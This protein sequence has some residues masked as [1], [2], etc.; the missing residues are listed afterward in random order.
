MSGGV[1]IV[2]GPS[3]LLWERS[4]RCFLCSLAKA[5]TAK[6]CR[7]YG[8]NN[9]PVFSHSSGCWKSKVKALAWSMTS[10]TS[11]RGSRG[12][13][14]GDGFSV[15]SVVVRLFTHT[16]GDSPYKDTSQ[17]GLRPTLMASF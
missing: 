11:L 8:L 3:I 5:A 10:K 15:F 1:S 17:I 9:S 6:Y 14:E 13:G 4:S 16:L 2:L 7:L 12:R